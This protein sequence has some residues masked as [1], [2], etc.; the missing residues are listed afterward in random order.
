[1]K[2]I[3][4]AGL[5]MVMLSPCLTTALATG[6]A[7][8][9]HEFSRTQGDEGARN[10][11]FDERT[12]QALYEGICQGCHM[13]NAKGAAGAGVYPALAGNPKLAAKLYPATMVIHGRKAMPGFG[14]ALDPTQ[15]A[16]VVNYVRTHFGNHYTDKVTVTEVKQLEK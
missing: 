4:A 1:M 12:G 11:H 3:N 15:V 9:E 7:T 16:A 5:A 6:P 10:T 2:L 13:S 14:G 8:Q